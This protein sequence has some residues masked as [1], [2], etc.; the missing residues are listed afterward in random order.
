VKLVS[1]I[2][3]LLDTPPRKVYQA[4]LK[5]ILAKD[6]LTE[7]NDTQPCIFVLSTGRVGSMTLAALLNYTDNLISWHEPKPILYP[8]SKAAYQSLSDI[9]TDAW[10]KVFMCLRKERFDN[11]LKLGRGYVETSPQATFLAPVI[12][13]A[14]SNVKFIYLV[15]HPAAVIRSGMRRNWYAGHQADENR[16]TPRLDSDLYGQ[17][18]EMTQF[19]KNAWLWAETNRWI[20]EFLVTIPDNRKF[21]L[22]SED[23]YLGQLPALSALFEF[24]GSTMPCSK[25]IE[26]VLSLKMNNQ[27]I[28]EYPEFEKWSPEELKQLQL[29]I[30]NL[31]NRLGYEL[32]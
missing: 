4:L 26:K 16:I 9:H 28:G 12:A 27:K 23:L 17:W 3:L 15:R 32:F 2:D 8:A 13:K 21:T 11:S 29:I 22:H 30:G 14:I 6:S 18:Q 25:K 24:C 20:L 10:N 5:R 1:L 19:Q 7:F 31:A